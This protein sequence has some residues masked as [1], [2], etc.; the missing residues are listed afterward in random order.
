MLSKDILDILKDHLENTI[1]RSQESQIQLNA[2]NYEYSRDY[3][4]GYYDGIIYHCDELLDLINL[5]IK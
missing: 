2:D 4:N 5:L 3:L 1:K